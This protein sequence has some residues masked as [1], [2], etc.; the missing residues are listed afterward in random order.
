MIEEKKL[1]NLLRYYGIRVD[2]IVK[3]SK[4]ILEK[5]NYDEVE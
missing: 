2:S 5:G 3:R 1:F 4:K